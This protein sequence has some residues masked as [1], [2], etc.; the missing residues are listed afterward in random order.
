MKSANSIFLSVILYWLCLIHSSIGG[1]FHFGHNLIINIIP[2]LIMSEEQKYL[3]FY[4]QRYTQAFWTASFIYQGCWRVVNTTYNTL[5]FIGWKI[6][7]TN[8]NSSF[9]NPHHFRP[10]TTQFLSRWC[11]LISAKTLYPT[12]FLP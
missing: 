1:F 2:K 3:N 11:P 6:I 5:I 10:V 12:D 8:F 4:G 9:L 7:G